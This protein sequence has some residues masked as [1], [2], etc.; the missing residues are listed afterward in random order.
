MRRRDSI[1]A[2]AVGIACAGLVPPAGAAELSAGDAAARDCAVRAVP[3]AAGVD[4]FVWEA[5]AAG[6]LDVDLAGGPGGDWDLAIFHRGERRAAGASTSFGSQER[7]TTWVRRGERLVVQGCRRQAGG[8]AAVPLSFDL[9]RRADMPEVDDERISLESVAISGPEDVARL[10]RLGL[11]VTHDVSPG[12][13]TV[14]LYSDAERALLASQRASPPRRWS[15]T[16]LLRTSADREAESRGVAR[17]GRR[18]SAE[19]AR[20]PTASTRT[21]RPR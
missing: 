4:R 12:A 11:D 3:G 15:R 5:P 16:S 17:R 7:V 9:F 2:V 10:E 21:T 19:R 1:I 6:L 20:P 14:A 8:P 18:R 13:A